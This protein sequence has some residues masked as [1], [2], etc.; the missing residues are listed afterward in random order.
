MLLHL[1][2]L[3]NQALQY[4]MVVLLFKVLDHFHLPNLKIVCPYFKVH[5][6]LKIMFKF[7]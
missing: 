3:F 5:K 4:F 7:R 1:L 6:N 2:I